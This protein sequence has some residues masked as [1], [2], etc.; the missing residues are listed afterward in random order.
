[1]IYHAS[2]NAL[3]PRRVAAALAD[4]LGANAVR[5]PNPP[6]PD[7]SWFVCYGDAQG[8]LIEVL[9]WGIVLDPLMVGGMD[10]DEQ[11]R[12]RSGFHVLVRT[13]LDVGTVLALAAREDWRARIADERGFKVIKIW[14]ENTFLIELMTPDMA[15]AYSGMYGA[16]GIPLLDERLRFIE[17]ALS[18]KKI[19][20]MSP[21]KP[22][23]ALA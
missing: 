12:S 21:E 1:M 11:M 3:N 9:P 4:L 22:V 18:M 7:G 6:F 23:K 5:A 19:A 14:I 13:P 17:T 2:F 15:E 10:H 20:P 16:R 8:S